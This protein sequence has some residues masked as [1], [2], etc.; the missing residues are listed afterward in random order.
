MKNKKKL[1]V[2]SI[3]LL[4]LGVVLMVPG[5][6]R[7]VLVF[8]HPEENISIIG[9]ADE[10]SL[11]FWFWWRG[12]RIIIQVL[13]GIACIVVGTVMLRKGGRND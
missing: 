7:V 6:V 8:L 2:L 5:I 12:T 9:G 11:W 4:L 10:P 3:L 1:K 13:V